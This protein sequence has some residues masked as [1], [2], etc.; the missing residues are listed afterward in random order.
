MKIVLTTATIA[1]VM[2]GV[3]NQA[4]AKGLC[5][6]TG[7]YLDEY[8]VATAVIKNRSGTLSAPPI[9]ATPYTFKI[10]NLTKTGFT[11]TGKNKTKS[12]GT[13][14]ATPTFMGSCSVF[15]GMVDIGGQ[16]LSDVF[17][18][19]AA[20]ARK[21]AASDTDLIKGFK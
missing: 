21:S 13:F 4:Y 12:C 17:T 14:S 20:A 9:C 2:F 10:T 18:K 19:Q 16:M 7:T 8:G 5:K 11:V 1:A 3:Y 6:L 15:G